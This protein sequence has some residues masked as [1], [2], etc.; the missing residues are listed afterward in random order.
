MRPRLTFSSL[1]YSSVAQN[2]L[3][4]A[5]L[6]PDTTNGQSA[7]ILTGRQDEAIPSDVVD[8]SNGIRAFSRWKLYKSQVDAAGVPH[9]LSCIPRIF[10]DDLPRYC[11]RTARRV[12][13]AS[14]RHRAYSQMQ[15]GWV[16]KVD[17]DQS[18]SWL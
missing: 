7:R 11:A 5:E 8:L 6:A 12:A 2:H 3:Q 14:L 10:I 16:V 1:A 4:L 13:A 18:S 9:S 15:Y 17:L